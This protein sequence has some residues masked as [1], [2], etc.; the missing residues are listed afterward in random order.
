M[1]TF[2]AYGL[3]YKLFS[4][5]DDLS[6]LIFDCN[7]QKEIAKRMIRENPVNW[8]NWY[9]SVVVRGLGLPPKEPKPI[10]VSFNGN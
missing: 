7:L 9:T 5:D 10:L 3:R 4:E 8:R 2:K 6:K 1:Q